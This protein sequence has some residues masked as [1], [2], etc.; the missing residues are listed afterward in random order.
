MKSIA[1]ILEDVKTQICDHYCKYPE[2]DIPEGKDED[3]LMDSD[4]PC[5][6]CPLNQL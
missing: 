5:A 3:W 1:E 2:Q 4:S 6:N